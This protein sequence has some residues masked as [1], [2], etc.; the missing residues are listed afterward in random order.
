MFRISMQANQL[1]QVSTEILALNSNY[2][3]YWIELIVFK[4]YK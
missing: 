4:Y 3:Q 2:F 1:K